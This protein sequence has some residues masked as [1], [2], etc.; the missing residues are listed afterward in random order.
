MLFELLTL[1]TV[2]LILQQWFFYFAGLILC[3]GLYLIIVLNSK[4]DL[5]LV[6]STCTDRPKQQH[7]CAVYPSLF[8]KAAAY[9]LHMSYKALCTSSSALW[10]SLIMI[11]SLRA[12]AWFL[13]ETSAM[14]QCGQ[15]KGMTNHINHSMKAQHWAQLTP[16]IIN[17]AIFHNE[18]NNISI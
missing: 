9:F 12:E 14:N 15:T 3:P 2:Y 6:L 5:I 10:D 7:L 8:I 18:R 16:I 1:V 4:D 13:L 11:M 17:K